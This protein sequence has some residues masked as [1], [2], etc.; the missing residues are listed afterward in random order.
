ETMVS[1]YPATYACV[2][3]IKKYFRQQMEWDLSQDECLYLM[4]HINRLCDNNDAD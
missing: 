1:T 4:L 3:K 2:T